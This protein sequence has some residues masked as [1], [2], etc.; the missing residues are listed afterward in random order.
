MA[1]TASETILDQAL[2]ACLNG[3]PDR[4]IEMREG[5]FIR[6]AALL[7]ALDPELSN[8]VAALLLASEP[9]IEP[10]SISAAAIRRGI[11]GRIEQYTAGTE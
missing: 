9:E 3:Q 7:H 4:P 1:A 5:L 6:A 2:R 10:Q 11:V 8:R